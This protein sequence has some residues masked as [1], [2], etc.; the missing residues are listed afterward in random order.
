MR[1]PHIIEAR[2]LPHKDTYGRPVV[3]VD[4]KKSKYMG[5]RWFDL[6]GFQKKKFE[7][8]VKA[9]YPGALVIY[10]MV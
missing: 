9:S 4:C 7:N 1:S 8:L 2:E 3:Q 5:Y 10:N 6:S